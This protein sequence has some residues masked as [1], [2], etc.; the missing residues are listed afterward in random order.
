M[1]VQC[2]KCKSIYNVKD[3]QIPEKGATA[4]CKKC[5]NKIVITK[6]QNDQK[7]E[8]DYKAAI[9]T[10]QKVRKLTRQQGRQIKKMILNR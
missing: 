7:S 5:G 10:N 8:K 4:T 9:E 3:E 1:K 2:L 6:P